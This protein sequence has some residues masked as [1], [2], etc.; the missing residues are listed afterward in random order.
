MAVDLMSSIFKYPG[1]T[2][3]VKNRSGQLAGQTCK[4]CKRERKVRNGERTLRDRNFSVAR[5]KERERE[6]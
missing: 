6:R 5:G 3:L 4:T 2:A 1:Q